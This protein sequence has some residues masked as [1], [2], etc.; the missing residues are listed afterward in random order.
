M[1]F[2]K[3]QGDFIQYLDADDLLSPGKIEAHLRMVS[4]SEKE[5]LSFG[6]ITHF[7]DSSPR[8]PQSFSASGESENGDPIEFLVRLWTGAGK[9]DMVQTGQWLTPRTLVQQAGFWN[10]S[11]TVD[12]DGEFFT[13]VILQASRI[14]AVPEAQTY[15]RKFKRGGSLS[16]SDNHT[17]SM[18][19]AQCK[20]LALLGRVEHEAARAAVEKIITREIVRAFPTSPA[21]V[22]SGF[23]FL[24]WHGL[25]LSDA[26]EGSPLYRTMS[27]FLG[28]KST[29]WLQWYFRRWKNGK[30]PSLSGPRVVPPQSAPPLEAESR[31][32][33]AFPPP[34]EHCSPRRANARPHV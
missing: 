5:A 7:Y 3:A 2:S 32:P 17:E 10:E 26:T 22:R 21:A 16:A 18:R 34:V 23:D 33:T 25:K 11:L 8:Q 31:H 14:V 15:Y 20:C 19:A 24:R 6:S 29:R 30:S 12:D 28:W 13:R 1:A 9:I 27:R 4:S